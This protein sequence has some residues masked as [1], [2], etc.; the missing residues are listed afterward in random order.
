MLI[1]LVM[2][3]LE[4]TEG[5]I[6][7]YGIKLSDVNRRE[8]QNRIAHELQSIHLADSSIAQNIEFGVHP[9]HI[10]FPEI[11]R[12]PLQYETRVGE[13]GVRRSVGQRNNFGRARDF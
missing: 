9:G 10:T 3:L 12:L 1:G 8:R 5:R 11:D 4:P 2:G 7:V 6:L 13:R